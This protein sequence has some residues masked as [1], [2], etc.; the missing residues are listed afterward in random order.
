MVQNV[1]EHHLE[2]RINTLRDPDVLSHTEVKIPIGKAA[3]LAKPTGP[4]VDTKD[5][6]TNRS[7]DRRWIGKQVNVAGSE[8]VDRVAA[9]E[10][11]SL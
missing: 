7:I 3:E 11:G 9:L 10:A 8:N 5:R 4:P 6:G 1:G 2:L